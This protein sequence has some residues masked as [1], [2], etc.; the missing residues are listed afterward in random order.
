M[1]DKVL[2]LGITSCGAVG[3]PVAV[4]AGGDDVSVVAEAV[5]Q[6]DGGGLVGKEPA[7]LFEWAV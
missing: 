5:E 1:A 7:P 4:A 6:G 2:A 3:E